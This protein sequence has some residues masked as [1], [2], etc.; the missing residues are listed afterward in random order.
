MSTPKSITYEQA[1]AQL[2]SELSAWDKYDTERESLPEEISGIADENLGPSGSIKRARL[3]IPF[4]LN[5]FEE[6]AGEKPYPSDLAVRMLDAAAKIL[7]TMRQWFTGEWRRSLDLDVYPSIPERLVIDA[8]ASIGSALN[9][10]TVPDIRFKTDMKRLYSDLW[11]IGGWLLDFADNARRHG[12]WP[13]DEPG[14]WDANEWCAYFQ[15][16]LC[17]RSPFISYVEKHGLI[18]S[19]LDKGFANEELFSRRASQRAKDF[20][21]R[22]ELARKLAFAWDKEHPQVYLDIEE[23]PAPPPEDNDGLIVEA[24]ELGNESDEP[25]QTWRR[26]LPELDRWQGDDVERSVQPYQKDPIFKELQSF[27]DRFFKAS[28]QYWEHRQMETENPERYRPPLDQ[29]LA[30]LFLCAQGV[31]IHGLMDEDDEV[32]KQDAERIKGCRRFGIQVLD[33]FARAIDA[34]D[35]RSYQDLAKDARRFAE[36]SSA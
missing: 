36:K 18:Q 30:L 6:D 4:I 24:I 16:N 1:K 32:G 14:K 8:G 25:E 26:S 17:R 3:L 9:K 33:K 15:R 28:K 10:W 19:S 11:I 31:M 34:C 21:R 13:P 2:L 5:R 12:E 35:N 20:V 22:C 27:A 7:S 29:Y 23:L